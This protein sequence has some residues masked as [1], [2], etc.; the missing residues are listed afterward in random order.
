MDEPSRVIPPAS[1]RLGSRFAVLYIRLLPGADRPYRSADWTD[2]LVV[3]EQGILELETASG[4]RARFVVGDLLCLASLP[5]RVLRD[6]G[7]DATLLSAVNR[8]DRQAIR[9]SCRSLHD[10][11][12]T[13]PWR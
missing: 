5:L 1:R 9:E 2:A 3:V 7:S 10:R 13:R 4:V 6:P 11:H 8:R 12:L